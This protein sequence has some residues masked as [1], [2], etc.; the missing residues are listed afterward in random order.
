MEDIDQNPDYGYNSTGVEYQESAVKD[1]NI[2]YGD[3]NE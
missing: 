1:T 2:Y 3:D